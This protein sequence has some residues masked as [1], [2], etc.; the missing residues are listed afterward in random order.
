MI[1]TDYFD[2][3]FALRIERRHFSIRLHAQTFAV[4]DSAWVWN[5]IGKFLLITKLTGEN[6]IVVFALQ[7]WCVILRDQMINGPDT[8]LSGSDSKCSGSKIRLQS[9]DDSCH[10]WN[11]LSARGVG[12]VAGRDMHTVEWCHLLHP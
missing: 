11:I 6:Q 5:T 7:F 10:K 4:G 9:T 1:Q 3:S 8:K 12:C 2:Q